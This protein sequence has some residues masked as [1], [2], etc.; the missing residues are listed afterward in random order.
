MGHGMEGTLR[1]GRQREREGRGREEKKKGREG[2]GRGKI[3]QQYFFFPTSSP[4]CLTDSSTA[5]QCTHPVESE[6]DL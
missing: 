1:E 4:G 5:V 6:D 3:P 2:K